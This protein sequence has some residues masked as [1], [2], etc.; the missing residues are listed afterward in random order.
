ME[1]PPPRTKRPR[2]EKDEKMES[3]SPLERQREEER[4]YG[5]VL[6]LR[7]E[8]CSGMKNSN[9][10]ELVDLVAKLSQEDFFQRHLSKFLEEAQGNQ[11]MAVEKY[12]ESMQRPSTGGVNMPRHEIVCFLLADFLARF[13]QEIKMT[14]G[15]NLESST[16]LTSLPKDI[17]AIVIANINDEK[18]LAVLATINKSLYDAVTKVRI[19]RVLTR[20]YLRNFM[21]HS[22]FIGRPLFLAVFQKDK[23]EFDKQGKLVRFPVAYNREEGYYINYLANLR[24]TGALDAEYSLFLDFF[25]TYNPLT[26]LPLLR[27]RHDLPP[28]R[29]PRN[30]DFYDLFQGHLSF[31]FKTETRRELP[32]IPS[33]VQSKTREFNLSKTLDGRNPFSNGAF[34]HFLNPSEIQSTNLETE[35]MQHLRALIEFYIS[36][37]QSLVQTDPNLVAYIF[38][39]DQAEIMMKQNSRLFIPADE[40][41]QKSHGPPTEDIPKKVMVHRILTQEDDMEVPIEFSSATQPFY[42]LVT[43]DCRIVE[44]TLGFYPVLS[45]PTKEGTTTLETTLSIPEN[46]WPRT[47]LAQRKYAIPVPTL[48][49]LPLMD[50]LNNQRDLVRLAADRSSVVNHSFVDLYFDQEKDEINLKIK[51]LALRGPSQQA[52]L[53]ENFDFQLSKTRIYFIRD[54]NEFTDDGDD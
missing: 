9:T 19:T 26:L 41:I 50:F 44:Q 36:K 16:L 1:L 31:I 34:L 14:K 52:D 51:N 28:S 40:A 11:K 48:L 7:E 15:R 5:Q 25:S 6:L 38:T 10:D 45:V 29:Q 22:A 53:L 39:A 4:F 47:K 30:V 24:F 2:Q 27:R 8:F 46:K 23:C 37:I 54:V 12:I 3:L 20:K 21:I 33:T 17:L 18:N 49:C 43:K 32:T 13:V 35:R 42:E